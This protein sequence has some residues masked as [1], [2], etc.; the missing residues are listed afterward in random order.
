[1]ISRVTQGDISAATTT[2][3]LAFLWSAVNQQP[4]SWRDQSRSRQ[5]LLSFSDRDLKDIGIERDAAY[6]WS[7]KLFWMQ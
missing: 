1:M 7:G 2:G 3:P 6:F 4:A 5:E